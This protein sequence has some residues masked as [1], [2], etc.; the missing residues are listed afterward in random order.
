M[1]IKL[2]IVN[3]LCINIITVF[4][5]TDVPTFVEYVHG[6]QLPSAA[7]VSTKALVAYPFY[8]H[9]LNGIRHLVSFIKLIR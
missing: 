4:I 6:L 8:Y 3:N 5:F 9:L 7:I 1:K 2:K